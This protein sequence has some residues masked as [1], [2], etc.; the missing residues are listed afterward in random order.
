MRIMWRAWGLAA[1]VAASL[2]LTN[3]ALPASD[4]PVV[5]VKAEV[6]DGAVRLEAQANAPFEYTTYRPSESLYV[7]DLSGVSAGD[8][9]GARVVASDL[10]KSYRVI[11][12]AAG[13]KPVVRLEILLSQGVEPRL[14]RK[15]TQDLTLLVSRTRDASLGGGSRPRR[16]KRTPVSSRPRR[17]PAE[18]QRRQRIRAIQQVHLAQNGNHDRSQHCRL[19]PPDLSR[20]SP[21]E[22]GPSGVGFCGLAF[23]DHEKHIAS[24]LDPVREIRLAQFTPEVSRVVID[25]RQPARYSIKGERK[26]GH[27][28]I[29]AQRRFGCRRRSAR[30]LMKSEAVFGAFG[31]VDRETSCQV[32][33]L[34]RPQRSSCSDAN[35]CR[36]SGAFAP[37][38][39]GVWHT[40]RRGRVL[41]LT[42]SSGLPLRQPR[43]RPSRTDVT[44]AATH[45][46]APASAT[47]SAGP[48][49][50]PAN[51]FQ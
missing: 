48:E 7:L 23:E 24:N 44:A 51:R 18:R 17:A 14:E 21:A 6:K 34:R 29:R 4:A 49:N 13:K 20:H 33:I 47:P 50:I 26:Y 43:V 45:G 10:V 31:H 42:R 3:G 28:F 46:S 19:R 5:H 25:L 2:I 27:G 40:Q 38:Q 22:S 11:T 9:A 41:Q 30:A 35:I 39:S 1:L 16:R 36:Y 37:L 12:Y 8:P 15:D 32:R